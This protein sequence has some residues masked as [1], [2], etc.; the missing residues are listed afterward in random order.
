MVISTLIY[1]VP[2]SYAINLL[3]IYSL[4]NTP[5][6]F[7]H[8]HVVQNST[9]L[10]QSVLDA[11][12]SLF[13]FSASYR[14]SQRYRLSFRIFLKRLFKSATTQK[15]FRHSTDTVLEFHAKAPQATASKGLAQGP[16]V[17]ASAGFEP[18]TLRLKGIDSTKAPPRPTSWIII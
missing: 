8:N 1:I 12:C 3:F 18:T 4:S 17:A 7:L 14:S 2:A 6:A 10:D 9:Y 13:F 11:F 15:R 16:Y 5:S